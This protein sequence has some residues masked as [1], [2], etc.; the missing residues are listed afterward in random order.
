MNGKPWHDSDE[1]KVYFRSEDLLY[2]LSQEDLDIHPK[3]KFGLG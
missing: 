3:I 1:N 2:S